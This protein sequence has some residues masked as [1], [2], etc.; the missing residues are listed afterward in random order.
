MGYRDCVV[1]ELLQSET[2]WLFSSLRSCSWDV[3]FLRSAVFIA[4]KRR[5]VCICL[6]LDSEK[7]PEMDAKRAERIHVKLSVVRV[8]LPFCCARPP[9][10]R[11]PS[12][13]KKNIIL[14]ILIISSHLGNV[15]V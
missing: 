14:I 3:N 4:M 11:E 6:F 12:R 7:D 8:Y 10:L 5:L 15:C 1:K 13:R 2:P 9:V